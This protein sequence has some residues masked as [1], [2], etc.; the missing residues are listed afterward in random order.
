[1][2]SLDDIRCR[3]IAILGTSL[4]AV[5]CAYFLHKQN[6]PI[7]CFLNT[8]AKIDTFMKYPVYEPDSDHLQ[9]G[10]YIIV[11]V[12]TMATYLDLSNQLR[13]LG[14]KEFVDYAYYKWINRELVLLHGNC[15]MSIIKEYLESSETFTDKYAIYPNPLIHNNSG[16]INDFVLSNCDIWIHEEILKEN[17]YGY[18]LSDEYIRNRFMELSVNPIELIIPNLFGLGKAFFLSLYCKILTIIMKRSTMVKI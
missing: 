7:N 2:I 16:G 8:A 1:M 18:F 13:K 5:K 14:L 4:D 10:T 17:K 6:I 11:A 12:G 3:N 9:T 15:H